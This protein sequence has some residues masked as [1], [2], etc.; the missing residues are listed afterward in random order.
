MCPADVYELAGRD[1]RGRPGRACSVTPSNCVQC[2][3][4]TAKGGRLTA[5]RGRQRA[6]VHADVSDAAGAAAEGLVPALRPR[7]PARGRSDRLV[8]A[9]LRGSRRG[10]QRRAVGRPRAEP[11]PRRWLERERPASATGEAARRGPA[12]ATGD[13][14]EAL[15]E[16]GSR[17]RSGSTSPRPRSRGRGAAFRTTDF[18]G[19]RPARATGG[20]ASERSTSSS[21]PTR[22]RRCRSTIRHAAIDGVASL[23]AP[24]GT[25]LVV[26][27]GRDADDDPGRL[28]WPLTREELARFRERG[29]RER[30]FEDYTDDVEPERRRFRVE[31]ERSPRS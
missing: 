19:R 5:A 8:R 23:V 10:R 13:D 6:R 20:H 22:C 4:I 24:G 30:R 15:R 2:G 25:L 17:R 12:A 16:H 9:G 18:R 1:R 26:T 14:A 7:A 29:L 3:A 21:R 31:Y 11:A 27:F 28:P